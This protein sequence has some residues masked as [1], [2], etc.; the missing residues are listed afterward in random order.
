MMLNL[1]ALAC[2]VAIILMLIDEIDRRQYE[3]AK[4]QAINLWLE[5]DTNQGDKE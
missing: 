4:Q 2:V 5:H 3:Y 1:I